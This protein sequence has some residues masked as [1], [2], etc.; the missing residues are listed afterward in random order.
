MTTISEDTRIAA[1][2][3]EQTVRPDIFPP[4][5]PHTGPPHIYPLEE[6]DVAPSIYIDF[7][8][9]NDRSDRPFSS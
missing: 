4:E 6:S 2:D 5:I 9:F 1:R 3:N 7:A 8:R